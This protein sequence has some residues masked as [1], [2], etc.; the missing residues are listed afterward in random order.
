MAIHSK[1]FPAWAVISLTANGIL[2]L[3]IAWAVLR[4]S[5]WSIPFPVSQSVATTRPLNATPIPTPELGPRHQLDYQQWVSLLEQ[6]ADVIAEQKPSQ[7]AILLGDSISL[8]FPSELLPPNQKWL[9]QGISGETS[10]GLLNRLEV[11]DKTQPEII[12]VMIGINDLIRGVKDDTILANQRLILRYLH[13]SHPQTQVVVQS[14]LPH[15]GKQ[16]TW[17]GRDRLLAIPNHRI[18]DIN[19]RL[20]AIAQSEGAIYLDLY[21]LFADSEGNLKTELSTDGLHLSPQGYLVWHYA[22]QV[23]NQLVLDGEFNNT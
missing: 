12:F 20:K 23:L 15:S 10:E 8:W 13:Q 3:A 14:I 16:A 9:N 1:T 11:L 6:E 5:P 4:Q 7:L 2:L 22:L 19:Q 17:E 18:Q 21:S